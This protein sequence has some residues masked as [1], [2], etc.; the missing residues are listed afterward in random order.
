MQAFTKAHV[1]LAAVTTHTDHP[2][3]E[4]NGKV[5]YSFIELTF[6]QLASKWKY[7]KI[8]GK[9]W[10]GEREMSGIHVYK[11]TKLILLLWCLVTLGGFAPWV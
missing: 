9:K 7:A 11:A 10:K 4:L 8:S 5:T 6:F 3:A 2:E 1:G